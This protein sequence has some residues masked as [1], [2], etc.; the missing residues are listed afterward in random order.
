[1]SVWL[2]P[3]SMELLSTTTFRAP[4]KQPAWAAVATW[5]ELGKAVAAGAAA[6]RRPGSTFILKYSDN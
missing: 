3:F 4:G 5:A 6:G 2:S 1:M